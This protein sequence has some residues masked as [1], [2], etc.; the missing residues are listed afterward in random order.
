MY[1]I[2]V[3]ATIELL[4]YMLDKLVKAE[5]ICWIKTNIE[6]TKLMRISRKREKCLTLQ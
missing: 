2:A 5:K 3:V 1:F 4:Q 6:K